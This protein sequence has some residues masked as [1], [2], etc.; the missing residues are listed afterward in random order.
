MPFCPNCGEETSCNPD[1]GKYKCAACGWEEPDIPIALKIR[2]EK[3][4]EIAP[5]VSCNLMDARTR[6]VLLHLVNDEIKK[7]GH[8]PKK[9]SQSS[10]EEMEGIKKGLE[11][12]K[13]IR[14]KRK[15]EQAQTSKDPWVHRY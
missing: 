14:A 1:N 7:L 11:M 6:Q 5:L 15:E 4:A 2:E 13:E 3:L 9:W 10:L 12:C 8:I